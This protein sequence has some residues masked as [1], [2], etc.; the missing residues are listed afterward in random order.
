MDSPAT[1]Q[2]ITPGQQTCK[3]VGR[4]LRLWDAINVK[5]KF[6]GPLISIDRV[7]LDEHGNM[8][9]LSMPKRFQKQFRPLLTEGNVY[10]VTDVAA[11]DIKNKTYVYHYHNYMLQFKNST[12]VH[13]LETR[14]AN[15]PKFSFNFCPFDKLPEMDIMTRPL[16]D[17][18]GVISHVGPFE[19]AS[20]TSQHKLRIIKIRNLDEQT[21]EIRLW[22]KH[23]EAFDEETLLKKSQEGI[24]VGIFAGVTA[25]NFL[26][27]L[28]IS[29]N[30]ATTI[31]IDL[32]TS[33]VNN[34]RKS[35]QWA[36]PTLQQ[37]LPQVV[38]LSPLQAAG[39][40]Y[41]LKEISTLPASSFQ[42]RASFS[43]IAKVQS[44]V[45]TANWYYKGCNRCDKGYNNSSDTPT[46]LCTN[47]SPKPLYKLPITLADES[48]KLDAIAF[49]T[50]VED[51]VERDATHTSQNMKIDPSE[52]VNVLNNAIG[53]TKLFHIVMKG[54]SASRFPINYI[55]KKS[56]TVDNAQLLPSIKVRQFLLI[57]IFRKPPDQNFAICRSND[58][59]PQEFHSN[60]PPF[61]Q[62][63]KD[64]LSNSAA[65]R[66]L[67]F[68]E[69]E[70]TNKESGESVHHT[71]GELDL[72]TVKRP[73][74]EAP[75]TRHATTKDC[76]PF[77]LN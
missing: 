68:P 44:I 20:P 1:L 15:I 25:G 21:Q 76:S 35:Y 54:D 3:V 10:M 75:S 23:G 34:Y 7:I 70:P 26:G 42:E 63:D 33:E 31:Y 36:T 13:H 49:S 11:V 2:S 59:T 67:E 66:C 29:S 65:K 17:M 40:L 62:S 51:L 60:T 28:T 19:Y 45:T 52:H 12:K 69:H 16:Q 6:A 27:K 56:F 48:G 8:A 4:L 74:Q 46:C 9:Q 73:K 57:C 24:V 47:S 5:S 18:I 50:V 58:N 64:K 14:G 43:T 39:K 32:D 53:K 30:S 77:Y 22:G 71:A 72:Q 61:Q 41:T 38:Y 55:I 37:Q